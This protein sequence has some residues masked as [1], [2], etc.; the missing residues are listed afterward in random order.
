MIMDSGIQIFGVRI[1]NL[2]AEETKRKISISIENA[3]RN[4]FVV[5]LN[6]EILLKAYQ[7]GSYKN[8][9]NSADLNI[10]D[11]FGIKLV[12]F[13]KGK[14][15]KSRFTGVDLVYFLLN[16][17][18]KRKKNV[19]IV[20]AQKSLS[21]SN[22]I[23]EAILEKYPDILAKTAY[24][25]AGQYSVEDGIIE[26]AEIIFVNFGAPDQEKF[27]F[28][29]RLR[30]PNAK[31]LVGVGGSFDFLTGNICRAPKWMRNLGIEWLW[32]LVQEPKRIRR[33]WNA[34]VVFPIVALLKRD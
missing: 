7:D 2:S 29:N 26:K 9:L 6:P 28:E 1:D 17:A 16:F 33:I 19:L 13:L 5:T 34:V 20:L 24:F 4:L 15:I 25:K 10:C 3:S 31:I 14:K 30:F 21:R 22:E 32:R 11:G 18:E 27:I 23:E 8:I 12:A